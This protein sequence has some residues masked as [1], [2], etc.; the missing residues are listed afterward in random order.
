MGTPSLPPFLLTLTCVLDRY[1]G[2]EKVLP[3]GGVGAK[4]AAVRLVVDVQELVVQEQ[5]L[6]L[7]DV[8]TE[9]TFEAA[10]RRW[11]SQGRTRAICPHLPPPKAMP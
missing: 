9:L 1:M 5:L 4:A 11:S 3:N 6:V 2:Q 8:V 7:T 10:K